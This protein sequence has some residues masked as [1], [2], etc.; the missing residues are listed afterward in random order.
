MG[1]ETIDVVVGLDD[2]DEDERVHLVP[3]E[4]RKPHQ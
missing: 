4:R 3:D 1:S 2:S